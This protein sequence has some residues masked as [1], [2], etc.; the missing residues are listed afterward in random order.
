MN[1]VGLNTT[2]IKVKSK[3]TVCRVRSYNKKYNVF[4]SISK[5]AS[6]S[7]EQ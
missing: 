3:K 4:N 7:T 2:F 1:I 6:Q 5:M